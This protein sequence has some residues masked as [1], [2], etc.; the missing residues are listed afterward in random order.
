LDARHPLRVMLGEVASGLALTRVPLAPL[1]LEAV[2]QLAE[3]YGIDAGELYRVTAGNPF[4]V[5]EVCASGNGGIPATVRD[6]VLARSAR[7][8]GEA[9][10]LPAA[11]ATVPPQVEL[12]LLEML[13][14]EHLPALEECL[15]SGMLVEGTVGAVAFR[16]ELARLAIEESIE[17]R[18]RLSLH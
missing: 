6:S 14:G 2:A 11:A 1:S 3:S 17:T 7:R 16:H 8:S 5:S 9:G 4:F 18:R 12:W 13:A 15:S 10:T